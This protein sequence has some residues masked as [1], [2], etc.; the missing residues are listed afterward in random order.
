MATNIGT[1][2]TFN[3]NVE[4]WPTYVERVELYFEAN[5]MPESKKTPALLS[6]MG[7]KTYTLLRNLMA[8]EKPATETFTQIVKTLQNH[9]S[10]EP[11]LIVERFRFHK[12]AQYE[13]E[14]IA[15]FVAELRKLAERCQFGTNLDHSLRDRFVCGLMSE[16]TQKRL[17][18]QKTLTF[19]KAVELAK[20]MESAA[21]ESQ[22]FCNS[23]TSATA[24][25][26]APQRETKKKVNKAKCYRCGGLNHKAEDC[27]YKD[28]E[29]FECQKKGHTRKMCRAKQ[30]KERKSSRVKAVA[31]GESDTSEDL[32]EEL[33]HIHATNLVKGSAKPI[34]VEANIEGVPIS[35]EVDTGAGVTLIPKETFFKKLKSKVKLHATKVVLK[36]YLGDK[37]P[38]HGKVKEQVTEEINRLVKEGILEKVEYSEWAAPVV[39]VK[40]PDG[41]I[42]LCGDYKVTINPELETT[43]YPLPRPEEF[44]AIF[45]QS[46]DK[47]LNGLEGVGCYLDDIII[48]GKDDEEHKRNLL[49]VVERLNQFNVKLKREK[50]VLFQVQIEYLGHVVDKVGLHP[51][52]S[53]VESLKSAPQP[54]SL[55]EVQSLLGF[56]NYYRKFIPNLSTIVGPIEQSKSKSKF[57]WT[58]ECQNAFDKVKEILSSE[59]VLVYFDPDKDVTLA[60]DASPRGIG[61]VIS[62]KILG[63][64]RPIAYVSRTLT[65]A[66][67]NYSQ[68]EK[69]AL[70]IVFGVR[71]FHQYYVANVSS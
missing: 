38:V 60:V 54:K 22:E 20:V 46:M 3:E 49:A 62:H 35:M 70:A 12:Q 43:E 13:N 33:L 30:K 24:H 6:L 44:P 56:L 15:T 68:L 42:R 9:L 14:N 10:P 32:E 52:P 57:E 69:E 29:C 2:E 19:I 17:L 37:I 36:T 39:P 5:D 28:K 11:L 1:I 8:P 41:K 51:S 64:E 31:E 61:A 66:E 63:E 23:E 45:Q 34:V 4:D 71:H 50:C 59:A 67:Q 7:S 58:V 26:V 25:R 21:K 18:T 47:I 16:S 48:T 27:Y 65:K 40:K 55:H 53:K